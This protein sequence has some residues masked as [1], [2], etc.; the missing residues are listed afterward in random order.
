MTAF[1][2]VVISTE[3]PTYTNLN[4]SLGQIIKIIEGPAYTNLNRLLRQIIKSHETQNEH[5]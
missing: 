1:A 4:R 2:L 5:E 3:H